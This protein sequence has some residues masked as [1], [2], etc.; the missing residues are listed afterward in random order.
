MDNDASHLNLEKQVSVPTKYMAV[1]SLCDRYSGLSFSVL[2]QHGTRSRRTLLFFSC[3]PT[4]TVITHS[5]EVF[6]D[7]SKESPVERIER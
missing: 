5:L 3:T 4:P 6:R 1:L 7:F 2:T